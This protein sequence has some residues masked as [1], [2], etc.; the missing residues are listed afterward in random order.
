MT[1]CEAVRACVCVCVCMCVCVCVCVCV[2]CVHTPKFIVELLLESIVEQG[3]VDLL[4]SCLSAHER[5]QGV[6]AVALRILVLLTEDGKAVCACVRVCLSVCLSACVCVCVCLSVCVC[7]CVRACVCVC[8]CVCVRVCMC[9]ANCSAVYLCIRYIHNIISGP[10]IGDGP[11]PNEGEGV[12]GCLYCYFFIYCRPLLYF[13]GNSFLYGYMFIY[14][15]IYIY[16]YICMYVCIY[17]IIYLSR[18][19][20]RGVH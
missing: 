10:T 2:F 16:I 4:C 11:D 17:I 20:R 14:V 15:Y 3:A 12:G 18:W 13:F 1:T 7:V 9:P 5:H 6:Q 8:V 19:R